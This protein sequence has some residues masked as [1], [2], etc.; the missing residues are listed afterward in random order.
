MSVATGCD[1]EGWPS[2]SKRASIPSIDASGY[3]DMA[4]AHTRDKLMSNNHLTTV[5]CWGSG[6]GTVPELRYQRVE[7]IFRLDLGFS[8]LAK[9]LYL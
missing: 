6:S 9:S 4:A 3:D 1:P 2:E 8:R 5:N 7:R